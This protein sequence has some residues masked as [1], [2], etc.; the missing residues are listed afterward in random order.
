LPDARGGPS[1]G[2]SAR[3]ATPRRCPAAAFQS[4]AL[5]VRDP[6]GPVL[7]SVRFGRRASSAKR[8]TSAKPR[9][10][11]ARTD[12]RSTVFSRRSKVHRNAVNAIA[13]MCGR[14]AVVEDVAKVTPA[15]AAVHLG[16]NH[17]V[18]PVLGGFDRTLHRI[19]EARPASPTLEFPVGHEQRL[20][21][22]D[23]HKRA[24]TFL[25]IERTAS[26]GLRGVCP[27]DVVLLRCQKVTPLSFGMRHRVVLGLHDNGS[28]CSDRGC[29]QWSTTARMSQVGQNRTNTVL[30]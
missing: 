29:D 18:A 14:G 13:Q 6:V 10:S 3:T 19:V 23:T 7:H 25:M 21:T 4:V 15:A 20:T 9:T 28:L 30:Y 8:Y 1:R 12:R 2:S 27:H 11:F 22:S 5:G 26:R 24:G 16:A 17:P